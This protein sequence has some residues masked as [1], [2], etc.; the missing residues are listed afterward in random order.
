MNPA[1]I[2]RTGL[3]FTGDFCYKAMY[4]RDT[5]C[6]WCIYDKVLQG[7]HIKYKLA[8]PKDNCNYHVSSSPIFHTDGSISKLT[9]SRDLTEIKKHDGHI[10]VESQL[11][12]GTK[13]Y[14]YLPASDKAIP[15]KEE[16]KMIKGH[17]R[18]LVMDDEASLRKIVGR[19]LKHLGY[20][21]EF[22]M[23][24]AEAI[25]MYKKAQESEKPYDAVILDLTVPGGMGGKEAINKLLEIDPEV[26]AIVYSGYSEDPVLANFQEYGFKGMMPKPFESLSL[27]K[28][29]HEVLKGEKE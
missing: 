26:K 9:I 2:K 7:E 3:D 12:I 1:M 11:G 22:A 13:C 17:G 15:E 29:L 24:G 28:E 18:I 10:A 27:G 16:V 23:D 20:E 6:P 25:R 14:V 8:S 19:M 4:N 21:S 5:K